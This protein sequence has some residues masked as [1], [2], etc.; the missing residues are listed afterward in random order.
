[1]QQM[2][3][4]HMIYSGNCYTELHIEIFTTCSKN[5]IFHHIKNRLDLKMRN[6]TKGKI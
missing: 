4:L 1:M 5:K 2:L 6:I 3:G